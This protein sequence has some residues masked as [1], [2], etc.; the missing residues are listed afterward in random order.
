MRFARWRAAPR[1][2]AVTAHP[3]AVATQ[4]APVIVR[5]VALAD[6]VALD[7]FYSA[8]SDQS[9]RQRFLGYLPGVG[10]SNARSFCM[11]DHEHSEGFVAVDSSDGRI[12]GHVCL[13]WDDRGATELA[14]A[15]E[16][17]SQRRGI[18]GRLFRAALDWGRERNLDRFTATAFG[19]N[20]GMLRLIASAPYPATRQVLGS[21]I[22]RIE[23][24]LE[25]P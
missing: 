1:S 20:V 14:I 24:P 22:V 15:V 18:G 13:V 16:D 25:A 11:P 17:A 4:P 10:V 6:T 3:A 21:G 23:I 7:A 5:T 9:Q 2:G 8:L 12:V 19:D